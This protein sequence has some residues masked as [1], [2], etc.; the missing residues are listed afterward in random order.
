MMLQVRPVRDKHAADA[1]ERARRAAE[2]EAANAA[3][4]AELARAK[5]LRRV[6]VR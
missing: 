2:R 3:M 6:I 1:H 5:A 4:A